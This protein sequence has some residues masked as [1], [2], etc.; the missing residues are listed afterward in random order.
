MAWLRR[1]FNSLRPKNVD[2]D[3]DR[4]I[5]FHLAERADDLEREGAG[6]TEARRQA[7]L[8]FGNPVVQRERTRDVD[9]AGW[10][11]APVRNVRYA[12]RALGHTP[13]FTLTV[14]L[15]LALGIGANTAVFSAIDAVLLKP[16]P[17]PDGDR[18]VLITQT[19]EGSGETRIAPVRLQDWN[20]LNSTFE[21][22][23]GYYMDD[24]VDTSRPLPERFRR[25]FVT[26][27]FFDVLRVTPA[28]G[29]AFVDSEHTIAMPVT[30]LISDRLFR[31]DGADP[32]VVEIVVREGR[33]L[34]N[35]LSA[36]RLVQLREALL[37]A[38]RRPG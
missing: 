34:A 19:R 17:F 7:R 35:G 14:V 36:E 3:I 11:G 15:T 22:I 27:G 28:L 20:Q 37:P 6:A 1:L 16:L 30:M 33:M 2:R 24:L 13:G 31:H 29:R 26:R 18:L 9:V 8:R 23:A 12:I 21:G 32:I 10:V 5:T 38:P 25:A 4:E